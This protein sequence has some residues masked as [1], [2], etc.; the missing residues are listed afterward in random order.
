[1]VSIFFRGKLAAL[2]DHAVPAVVSSVLVDCGVGHGEVRCEYQ[3]VVSA[4]DVSGVL[5]LYGI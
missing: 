2:L 4:Q 3:R 1:M 5:D